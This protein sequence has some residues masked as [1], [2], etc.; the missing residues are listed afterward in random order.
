MQPHFPIVPQLGA[1]GTEPSFPELTD[2]ALSAAGM[3]K[4]AAFVRS[5]STA[6]AKRTNKH[7]KRCA[8]AGLRQLNVVA[9]ESAHPTIKA[10]AEQLRTGCGVRAA[11]EYVLASELG[12][13]T[14]DTSIQFM[15]RSKKVAGW[16][17]LVTRVMGFGSVFRATAR[18][19][20]RRS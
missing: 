16:R 17:R 10:I 2:D 6:Q 5:D 11:L 8:E 20:K 13:K 15:H 1:T 18:R 12:A 14:I 3:V 7:R 9:P 19:L 4:V